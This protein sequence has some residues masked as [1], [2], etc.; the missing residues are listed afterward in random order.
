MTSI[1]SNINP[2]TYDEDYLVHLTENLWNEANKHLVAKIIS[3]FYHEKIIN[4][5]PENL[6]G[7]SDYQKWTLQINSSDGEVKYFFEAKLFQLDHLVINID[8]LF[9]TLDGILQ[10]L[11]AISLIIELRNNL[12]ISDDLLPTYIEE[13]ISTLYS[14]AFKLRHKRILV[15]DLINADYQQIE[16]AMTEGHP[17]FIANNGRIG[18]DSIDYKNYS[19]E[20]GEPVKLEW[21]AISKKT[22]I[23]S[24]VDDMTYDSFMLN[25]LGES[26]LSDFYSII[27]AHGFDPEDYF[28]MPVHPWQWREKISRNF[29]PDLAKRTIIYL[30]NSQDLYQVQ[31]SI[32]TLFNTS[33]PQKSYVKT[34]LSILNMGFMRGLSPKYMQRTPKI[35]QFIANLV[36]NDD[37]FQKRNFH[38]LREIAGVGYY[39][40]YFEQTSRSH[41]A[42]RKMLAGLWRESPF[43]ITVRGEKLVKSE[44]K[45]LTMAALLHRD[46]M[47]NSFIV[48]LI[49]ASN[50]TVES[51]V[52]NFLT[53]Y[54]DPLLHAFFAHDLV[55]MPHGENLIFI[56]ENYNPIAIIMKDIGE[57][58]AI[59]NSERDSDGVMQELSVTVEDDKKL[60]YILLDVFDCIFRFIAPMLDAGTGLKECEFWN[61]VA[62]KV[63]SYQNNHPQFAKKYQRY[64]LFTPQF[65]RT[66]LNR[67]QLNNNQQMI[68]LEDREKNLRFSGYIDNPLYRFDCSTKH[69]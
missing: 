57:E 15:E 12:E 3:E 50:L 69:E 4:P 18:F 68:D 29:S 21:I 49:K 38:V 43:E 65:L 30:G 22:S 60:N 59:L 1:R 52:D 67:I 44:H 25:E 33:N 13:I 53:L 32:R 56:M 36:K 39:H 62:N 37:F 66:C 34:A 55:F 31:Q 26:Q 64:N 46:H 9:C 28:L 40:G 11:D 14:K 45:L 51:W 41:S 2:R 42:Y 48:A 10:P 35:N 5:C 24:I 27:K 6:S 23:F 17:V 20:S 54:L 19:P 61:M 47:G 8:T 58:V 7:R 16:A 63:L